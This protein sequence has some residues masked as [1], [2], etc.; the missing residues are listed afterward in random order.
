DTQGVIRGLANFEYGRTFE[1]CTRQE[2]TQERYEPG[3][4]KSTDG[5]P[6]QAP[7]LLVDLVVARADTR[8]TRGGNGFRSTHRWRSDVAGCIFGGSGGCPRCI[9]F[10]FVLFGFLGLPC[11]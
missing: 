2:K 10:R 4:K 11:V 3:A 9:S 6:R 5:A 1:E 7:P 8:Q